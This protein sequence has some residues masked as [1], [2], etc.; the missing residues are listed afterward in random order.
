MGWVVSGK[1][2]RQY[3][4]DE[5]RNRGKVEI[6]ARTRSAPGK[7]SHSAEGKRRGGRGTGAR[8]LRS[9]KVVCMPSEGQGG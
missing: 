3:V 5:G 2:G 1:R 4:N 7:G 6:S 8:N 9:V